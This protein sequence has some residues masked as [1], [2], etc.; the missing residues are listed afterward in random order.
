MRT[1]N[2]NTVIMPHTIS[3]L[4]TRWTCCTMETL[5]SVKEQL[6]PDSNINLNGS[7]RGEAGVQ[8]DA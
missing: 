8:S 1:G 5:T 7:L 6:W 3:D 4:S 2:M